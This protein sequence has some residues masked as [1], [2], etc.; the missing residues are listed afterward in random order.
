MEELE[1]ER[2]L[3][4]IV[5]GRMGLGGIGKDLLDGRLPADA[6]AF[7]EATIAD[8][9]RLQQSA[10]EMGNSVE[11]NMRKISRDVETRIDELSRGL[12]EKFNSKYKE[13]RDLVD[14]KAQAKETAQVSRGQFWLSQILLAAGIIASMLIAVLK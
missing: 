4:R 7:F 10:R 12:E 14:Q 13:I 8:L 11:A 3:N 1:T 9:K 5:K 2:E 6:R